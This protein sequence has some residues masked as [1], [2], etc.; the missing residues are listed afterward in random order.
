MQSEPSPP[1]GSLAPLG[2]GTF[3]A[4]WLATMVSNFGGLIQAVGAAWLMTTLTRSADMVA[5]V[6]SATALPIMLL[7]LASGAVADSFDRRRVM[8]L[9]QG[10]MLVVSALLAACAWAGLLS[11]WLLLGF[12]FLI[13]CGTALNNPS[14][15]ASVGDVVP[16][17]LVPAAVTLNSVAFN[18]TRSLG[19]AIGGAIVAAG[20]AAAAFAINAASYLPLILVLLRWRPDLPARLLPRETLGLAMG[21]GLRYVAMSPHL[22]V[23]LARAFSFGLSS[24]A[25]LALLPLVAQ[26]L[27]GGG[28]LTFGVL[29]GAFGVGAVAAAF[30][31]G[32]LR[33]AVS[34]EA[35]VRISF[36]GFALCAGVTALSGS[37]WLT[38]FA[39]A[40]G[41]ASWVT[42]LSLF[43]ITVQLS[44]PRWVVGRALALYQASTFGGM[45]V[46][47]WCWGLLAEAHGLPV[48]LGAAAAAMLAAG[49]L[50]LRYPLPGLEHFPINL[51]H[52]QRRRSS[53]RIPAA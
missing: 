17:P 15:Q 19:P 48:A 50:G 47:S 5:L 24:I 44:T 6:Q 29:L 2:N 26:N 30:L 52:N 39:L 32:R 13:G 28:P 3:R 11:P 51:H 35:V 21:A 8:M 40:A 41:G 45:A 9:A 25:V 12:T 37:V 16:R 43:N 23:I 46:G 14:W 36:A 31:S 42:A 18:I 49:A 1:V 22:L 34:S 33:A 4:I 53:W 7:S 38:G 27:V 20:G 10:F